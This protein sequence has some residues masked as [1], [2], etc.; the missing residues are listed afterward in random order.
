MFAAFPPDRIWLG[1]AGLAPAG[2]VIFGT[3]ARAK[4]LPFQGIILNGSQRV[5]HA[6]FC[7]ILRWA[8]NP[9]SREAGM[10]F[11]D[12]NWMDIESYLEQDDRLILV[13]GACEQ[14]GYLSLTSD[15]RIPLA[16]AD[17]VSERTGVLVAPPLGFGVSPYF[18]DF[19]GTISLRVG[20]F[21][22]IVDDIVRSVYHQGF[23]GL[24]VINGHGGNLAARSALYE[25]VNELPDLRVA[26][27]SWWQAPSVIEVEKK[28]G[29]SGTHA[30]WTEAFAFT[31]V[32]PLPE[33]EK[34][35]VEFNTML[36][37]KEARRELG[38]G[39]FG[40]K[41]QVDEA[42]MEEFFEVA[43]ESALAELEKITSKD[44]KRKS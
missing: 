29:L 38:D 16:I 22:Q 24:L 40:G 2:K 11:E 37:A 19:P 27:L 41:Y 23:R 43:V 13:L 17:S 1:M 15:T 12:L 34:P 6:I 36:S 7:D 20:V 25:L 8:R 18:I 14:H 35:E 5:A 33:E 21:L 31:R 9:T 42:I 30:N 32:A 39:M 3:M 26:W 4:Q 10:R 28:H 44:T